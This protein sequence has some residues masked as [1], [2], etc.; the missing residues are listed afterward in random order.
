M[1]VTFDKY[2]IQSLLDL[3][4]PLNLL[5]YL[6]DSSSSPFSGDLLY[7]HP[8]PKYLLSVCLGCLS[9][10]CVF[11]LMQVQSASC[12]QK[13]K[14][15]PSPLPWAWPCLQQSLLQYPIVQVRHQ[16]KLKCKR[17][18]SHCNLSHQSR[19]QSKPCSPMQSLPLYLYSMTQL[20]PGIHRPP[21][22]SKDSS[23]EFNHFHPLLVPQKHQSSLCN[24]QQQ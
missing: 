13:H 14:M 18:L 9:T 4:R 20:P 1:K 16:R 23:M 10:K 19:Q 22:D 11:C 8:A 12:V 3:G 5:L 6:D 2:G 17:R 15:V 24:K 7:L 21:M